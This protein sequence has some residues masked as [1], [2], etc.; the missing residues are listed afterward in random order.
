MIVCPKCGFDNQLGHIFCT[1]CRAKLDLRR[2]SEQDFLKDRG[3]GNRKSFRIM[4]AIAFLIIV[5]LALVCFPAAVLQGSVTKGDLQQARRKIALLEKG[6]GV[7]PQVFTESEVNACLAADL[8]TRRKS[9]AFQLQSVRVQLKP[10]A[11]VLSVAATLSP[12][13]AGGVKLGS[14]DLTYGMTGVPKIGEAGSSFSVSRGMIGHLPLPGPLA[15]ML[16]PQITAYFKGL[17]WNYPVIGVIQR[18][19]L[20]DG[21]VT[22]FLEK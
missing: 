22:V 18:F 4:L 17:R 11:V 14:F 1:Q 21:K 15:L 13:L 16:A 9:G 20:E 10:N 5:A 3:P 19:E 7:P 12:V 2:V 8:N 6:G